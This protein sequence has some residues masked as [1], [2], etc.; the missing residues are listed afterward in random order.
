MRQ[1]DGIPT[2]KLSAVFAATA[3]YIHSHLS[4]QY[5][6]RGGT[7][8]CKSKVEF[9]IVELKAGDPFQKEHYSHDVSEC[10]ALLSSER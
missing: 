4:I 2:I 7:D 8:L 6:S 1:S 3:T 9:A 10:S 5:M